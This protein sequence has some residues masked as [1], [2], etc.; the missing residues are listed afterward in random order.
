VE[1]TTLYR[2]T[3]SPEHVAVISAAVQSGVLFEIRARD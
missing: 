3:P 2:A 1:I